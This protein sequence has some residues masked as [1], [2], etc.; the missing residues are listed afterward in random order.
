[1]DNKEKHK[2]IL[3]VIRE[4]LIDDF[5]C[6]LIKP[7]SGNQETMSMYIFDKDTPDGDKSL[8]FIVVGNNQGDTCIDVMDGGPSIIWDSKKTVDLK[9]INQVVDW[10][11]SKYLR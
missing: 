7:L 9:A 2:R 11:K 1:M 6:D 3:N 4:N 8:N 10:L 5:E